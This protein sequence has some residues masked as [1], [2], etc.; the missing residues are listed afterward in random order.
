[1]V[2]EIL[3]NICHLLEIFLKCH[4]TH[5]DEQVIVW[6][7]GLDYGAPC[8]FCLRQDNNAFCLSVCLTLSKLLTRTSNYLLNMKGIPEIDIDTWTN[9]HS[10]DWIRH[11][12]VEFSPR[13]VL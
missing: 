3:R 4:F 6:N 9:N 7:L 5:C 8:L 2:R 1:M 10:V 13:E 12:S 11:L